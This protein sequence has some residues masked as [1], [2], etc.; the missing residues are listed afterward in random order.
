MS[1]TCRSCSQPLE[2]LHDKVPSHLYLKGCGGTLTTAS[3]GFSSPNYPLPYHPNAECYWTIRTSQGNQ[4]HLSF[5]DF[6]L[7]SSASCS[8]DYLAVSSSQVLVLHHNVVLIYFYP[9]MFPCRTFSTSIYFRRRRLCVQVYDGSSD[10]APQLGRLCGSQQPS[11]INSTGNQLYIKL[12]TDSSVAA[13][14]F[15]ASYSTSNMQAG[16]QSAAA[17]TNI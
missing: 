9:Q 8:Y 15:L 2:A 13:G 17:R 3:G 11:T 12:R 14:G 10:G 5:S 1:T 4:L 7:E 6:H 16:K